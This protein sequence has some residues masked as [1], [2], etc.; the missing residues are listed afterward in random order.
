MNSEVMLRKRKQ[1]H[2]KEEPK[3]CIFYSISNYIN[4]HKKQVGNQHQL[5]KENISRKHRCFKNNPDAMKST[6]G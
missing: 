2:Q 5:P 3:M 6:G 4:S 1:S